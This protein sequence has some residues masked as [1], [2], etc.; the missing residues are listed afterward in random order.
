MSNSPTNMSRKV[1]IGSVAAIRLTATIVRS[2]TH[3]RSSVTLHFGTDD[4]PEQWGFEAFFSNGFGISM[5]P[6]SPLNAGTLSLCGGVLA[7]LEEKACDAVRDLIKWK[8]RSINAAV[9]KLSNGTVFFRYETDQENTMR[10]RFE[11]PGE[12]ISIPVRISTKGNLVVCPPAAEHTN[13]LDWA[14]YLRIVK[15][16]E[17][18]LAVQIATLLEASL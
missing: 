15:D 13:I 6:I 4:R 2:H 14:P 18:H 7:A 10:L 12:S 9:L 17:H 1:V 3:S 5:R 16:N 8:H 11:Q